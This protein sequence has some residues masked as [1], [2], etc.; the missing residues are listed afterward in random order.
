MHQ[1][2]ALAWWNG[3]RERREGIDHRDRSFCDL[4]RPIARAR[5]LADPSDDQSVPKGLQKTDEKSLLFKSNWTV[6]TCQ[7]RNKDRKLWFFRERFDVSWRICELI[8]LKASCH[9]DVSPRT[10]V[11]SRTVSFALAVGKAREMPAAGSF[12]SS[13]PEAR[14]KINLRSIHAAYY[15]CSVK[16]LRRFLISK[17]LAPYVN[18]S[19]VRMSKLGNVKTFGS[20]QLH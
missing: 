16:I 6:W 18:V 13:Y 2:D 11:T 20:G 14:N 15:S 10:N 17:L 8:F 9:L 4:E 19:R 12:V 5:L 7:W 3:T 1:R